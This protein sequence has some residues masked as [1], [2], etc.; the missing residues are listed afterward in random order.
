MNRTTVV[1]GML[2]CGFALAGWTAP[3]LAQTSVTLYGRVASGIDYQNNVAP[4]ATSP[5]GSLWR[6][7]DNQ[8]GTSMFGFM[9]KED[10]GGGLQ[11][12]FRLESGFGAAQG[13]TNGDALFNRRSYV[14]LSSPTYGT[15]TVGKNLFISND[16]WYLDPTGQQFIGSAT[17]V[18]GEQ[19]V[20]LDL[21]RDITLGAR[22]ALLHNREASLLIPSF[23]AGK[24][25]ETKLKGLRVEG[26][27]ERH[28]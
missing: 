28:N 2:A 27:R 3:A 21:T 8:W 24:V 4:T 19:R 20:A 11:A 26:W 9:G 18:R 14:G 15:L 17:L 1:R 7:A 13:K 22:G 23:N 16:V 25:V 5:G 12:V 6:A 10:L